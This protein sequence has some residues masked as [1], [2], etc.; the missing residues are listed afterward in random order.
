MARKGV[1]TLTQ[2]GK[3]LLSYQG[4]ITH[5][6]TVSS[7]PD[8]RQ[9]SGTGTGYLTSWVSIPESSEGQSWQFYFQPPCSTSSIPE[10]QSTQKQTQAL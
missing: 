2:R 5:P 6:G 7:L 3:F 4:L 1:C 8:T 10:T 9:L